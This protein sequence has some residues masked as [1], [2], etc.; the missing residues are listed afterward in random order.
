MAQRGPPWAE[1]VYPRPKLGIPNW[2]FQTFGTL[3]HLDL[4]CEAEPGLL[5]ARLLGPHSELFSR[6]QV[7]GLTSRFLTSRFLHC[8]TLVSG[9]IVLYIRYPDLSSVV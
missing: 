9:D 8:P 6:L 3:K 2:V 7:L 4:H 5:L 1:R